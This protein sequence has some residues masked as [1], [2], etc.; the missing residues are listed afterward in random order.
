MRLKLLARRE[1]PAEASQ[2]ASR[3]VMAVDLHRKPDATN[4]RAGWWKADATLS[5]NVRNGSIPLK[6]A[7]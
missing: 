5:W 4:D 1:G 3:T 7:G 6:K 2:F